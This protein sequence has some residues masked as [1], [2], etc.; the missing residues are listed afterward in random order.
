[1][2]IRLQFFSCVNSCL[3]TGYKNPID[4]AIKKSHKDLDIS[5]CKKLDEIPYDFNRKRLSIL[6]KKDDKNILITKGAYSH[7]MEVCKYAEIDGKILEDLKDTV[8]DIEKLYTLYSSQGYKLIAVS[9]KYIDKE[10]IDFNDESDEIF[11]GFVILHD[12]LKS[13]AKDLVN[14]L[15]DLG[16]EL[17]IITGDNKLVA[18]HIAHSLGLDGKVLSGEDIKHLSEDA[19][20]NKVKDTFVFCRAYA[21][22]KRFGS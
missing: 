20:I 16:I 19:L 10:R 3:Q 18:Q 17:R 14:R 7:I 22:S 13:D 8:Q 5:N 4:D 6:V 12:P 15:K 11:I 1:M 9:Y 21:T 2:I